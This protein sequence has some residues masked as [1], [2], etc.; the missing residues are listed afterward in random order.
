MHVRERERELVCVRVVL[1]GSFCFS[2]SPR[3]PFILPGGTKFLLQVRH[4]KKA[5]NICRRSDS[6]S[7]FLHFLL[8]TLTSLEHIC[9]STF[10]YG[11]KLFAEPVSRWMRHGAR[12]AGRNNTHGGSRVSRRSISEECVSDAAA[13]ELQWSIA[14]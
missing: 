5:L 11:I 10:N 13:A 8:L 2:L 4:G 14:C 6:K 12:P 3:K 9:F 7:Y 1:C